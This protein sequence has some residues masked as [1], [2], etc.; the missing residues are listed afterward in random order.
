MI[1]VNF[2]WVVA[3]SANDLATSKRWGAVKN[4]TI[5]TGLPSKGT[6]A[7]IKDR[8][9]FIWVGTQ[10]GLCRFDGFNFKVFSSKTGDRSS[11]SNNY[12]NALCEDHQGR[13]WVGTME[14]LN[15]F[16]PLSETFQRF[17]HNDIKPGSLSNN[18][19][20]SVL[21]DRKGVVWIGTDDGF[22]QYLPNTNEFQIY[23]PDSSKKSA[24]VGKSVNA[25]IEDDR[26]N[27]WLGNWSGGLN[28]FEKK[29]AVYQLPSGSY[30]S[31][32]KP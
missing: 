26:D 15:L 2:Q 32:K 28:R 25:I 14:G 30:S 3:Q 27:L 10:N 7:T 21:C 29:E 22:N 9:G 23:R 18:K 17:V 1:T 8:R 5:A 19:V 11:I 31:E 24:M 4:Y 6:T 20:W 13:I 12:I 16:D